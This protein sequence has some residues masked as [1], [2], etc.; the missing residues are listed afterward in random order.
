MTYFPKSVFR[1][2]TSYLLDPEFHKKRHAE[3][4]QTI[5]VLRLISTQTTVYEDDFEQERSFAY[6]VYIGDR[7]SSRV[8]STQPFGED[9]ISGEWDN[10]YEEE[11]MVNPGG[12]WLC[13]AIN[14][15]NYQFD[16]YGETETGDYI[17]Q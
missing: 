6:L 16:Q 1:N 13:T 3:V 7:P 4:W 11:D 9:D 12:S 14:F 2:V 8:E 17:V 10:V 15:H 5:R